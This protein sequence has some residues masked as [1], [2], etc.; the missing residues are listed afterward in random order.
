MSSFG[1]GGYGTATR[2]QE[3]AKPAGPTL[4]ANPPR[5]EGADILSMKGRA[6][7]LVRFRFSNVTGMNPAGR[8]AITL[9]PSTIVMI[10]G[11]TAGWPTAPIEVCLRV[12]VW[13]HSPGGL[14]PVQM[15]LPM[16]EEAFVAVLRDLGLLDLSQAAGSA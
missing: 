12:A 10:E 14:Q 4:S 9:D 13:L 3:A 6:S 15:G 8:L 5:F 1:I 16:T 11:D 7:P 2:P